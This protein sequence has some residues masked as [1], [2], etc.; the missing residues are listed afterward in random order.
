MK[1]FTC[2]VA[3]ATIGLSMLTGLSPFA[4]IAD[5]GN[6]AD[7]TIVLRVGDEHVPLADFNHVFSKNNRDS[8]HTIEALD[9]Y[10]E[11][12]VNFKLKVLEAESLGMD[13]VAS[14]QKELAG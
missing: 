4:Q 10:M 11:L 9:E 13:T 7:E 5:S 2:L 6:H 14:F 1:R 8:V 3:L 12:F